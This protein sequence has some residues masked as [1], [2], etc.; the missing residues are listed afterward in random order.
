[1][2]NQENLIFKITKTGFLAS[3]LMIPSNNPTI[4][5]KKEKI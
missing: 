3:F 2:H 5:Y 1:M 4:H